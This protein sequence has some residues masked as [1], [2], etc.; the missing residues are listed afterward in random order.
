[1]DKRI[2]HARI[3]HVVNSSIPSSQTLPSEQPMPSTSTTVPFPTGCAPEINKRRIW[4][5][6]MRKW[7][8]R[9]DYY[10]LAGIS[11]YGYCNFH[12]ILEDPRYKILLL[13]IAE[14]IFD[15]DKADPLAERISDGK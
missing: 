14:V 8:E 9:H 11:Y 5:V 13:G 2:L 12:D 3:M 6:I 15:G 1:M 7:H 10:L 4:S